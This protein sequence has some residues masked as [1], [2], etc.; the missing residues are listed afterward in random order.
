MFGCS[1][2][3]KL[4]VENIIRVRANNTGAISVALALSSNIRYRVNAIQSRTNAVAMKI[5]RASNT[6]MS[7]KPAQNVPTKLP[8]APDIFA[9]PTE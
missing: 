4:A 7:R 6:G 2:T 8:N 5:I 1:V 3:L 9:M